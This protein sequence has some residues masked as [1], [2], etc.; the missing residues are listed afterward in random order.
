MN[1]VVYVGDCIEENIDRLGKL[2]GELRLLNAPLFIFQEG[3]IPS[4]AAGLHS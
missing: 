2:A 1:A 3:V 4:P